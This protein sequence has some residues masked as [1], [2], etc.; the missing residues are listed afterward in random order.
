VL[1]FTLDKFY[2]QIDFGPATGDDVPTLAVLPFTNICGDTVN[3]P[4]TVGI[5]DNLLIQLSKINALRTLSRRNPETLFYSAL[6]HLAKGQTDTCFVLLEEA[7][8]KT[9][10][11]VTPSRSTRT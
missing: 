11:T 9:I 6:V 3:N 7:V 1:L 5:H 4:F 8:A 2:S 10:F